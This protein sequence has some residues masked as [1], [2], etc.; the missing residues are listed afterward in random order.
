ME[1]PVIEFLHGMSMEFPNFAQ[2]LIPAQCP[3]SQLKEVRQQ[4][5]ARQR[6]LAML[7][8]QEERQTV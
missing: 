1:T 6:Q 8:G 3:G 7:P 5:A 4:I 2:Q